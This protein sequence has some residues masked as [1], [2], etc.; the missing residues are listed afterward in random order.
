MALSFRDQ[1]PKCCLQKLS[2]FYLPMFTAQ[3]IPLCL[4]P[5]Q[6]GIA[7]ISVTISFCVA[8]L[9]NPSFCP[10][11]ISQH[12]LI[13]L[14]ISLLIKHSN[15][16]LRKTTLVFL[17]SHWPSHSVFLTSFSAHISHSNDRAPQGTTPI[18]FFSASA[19]HV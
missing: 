3:S 10:H 13:E 4:W 7:P 16:G 11:F 2:P 17:L 8:K 19:Y 14:A 12:C 18:S 9:M 5:S 15:P 1:F 6:H